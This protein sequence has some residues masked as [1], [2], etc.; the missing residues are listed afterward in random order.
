MFSFKEIL[1]C[2]LIAESGWS[3]K[4]NQSQFFYQSEQGQH[5]LQ[6]TLVPL[7]YREYNLKPPAG[8]SKTTGNSIALTYQYGLTNDFALAMTVKY[9]AIGDEYNS[10]KQTSKGLQ[11]IDTFF[12]GSQ[13]QSYGT[14]KYGAKL[15]LS[16][17][18]LVVDANGNSNGY[19]GQHL[20]TPYVGYEGLLNAGSFG[21]K[22]ERDLGI[23]KKI[24]EFS[25]GSKLKNTGSEATT[26]TLFYEHYFAGQTKLGSS[27]SWSIISDYISESGVHS[28]NITPLQALSIYETHQLGLGVL[29]TAL[30]Y[31]FTTDKTAGIY[32]L[33]SYPSYEFSFG[34]RFTL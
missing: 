27:F 11:N 13:S 34:Y 30:K 4:Q 23:S 28:D 26:L 9:S 21:A 1:I 32:V 2:I 3:Q 12:M 8:Q 5:I 6:P 24:L 15:S 17:G 7:L 25:D 18:N 31:S 10:V 29:I 22:V 16:P 33:E 14:L 19:T 20:L